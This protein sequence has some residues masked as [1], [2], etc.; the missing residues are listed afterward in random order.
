MFDEI[1]LST[2]LMNKVCTH[3][4][5]RSLSG[6]LCKNSIFLAI[7]KTRLVCDFEIF[8]VIWHLHIWNFIELST[9]FSDFD[10]CSLGIF[11]TS[12][13]FMFDNYRLSHLMRHP[14][15]CAVSGR[16]CARVT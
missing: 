14:G 2:G 6:P 11:G 4:L 15:G 7:T 10:S 9:R 5:I 16:C 1:I 3:P 8:H 12:H 13:D